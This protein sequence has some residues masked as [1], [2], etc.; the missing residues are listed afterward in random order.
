MAIQWPEEKAG[1]IDQVNQTW[2]YQYA[3]I[4]IYIQ[5]AHQ[6]MLM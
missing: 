6:D 2:E 5:Q 3:Y 4:N 1:P